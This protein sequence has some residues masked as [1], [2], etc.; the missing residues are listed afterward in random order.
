M[1]R[2]EFIRRTTLAAGVAVLPFSIKRSKK[3]LDKIEKPVIAGDWV[4]MFNPNDTRSEIATTWYTND[5]C[6]SKGPE[7]KWHAYGIIGHKPIDPW[8]GETK[9]FH[10]SADSFDQKRW[11]DHDYA[12]EVKPGVERV[13][14]AP[15]VYHDEGSEWWHMFYNIGNRQENAPDYASWGQL[16]RADSKDMFNW[17][18]H[19]LNP[20][21]SDPGHARDSFVTKIGDHYHFYYTRTLN[22]VDLRSAVALRTS[23]DLKYWSGAQIVHIQPEGGHWAGNTESPTVIERNSL[24]YLFI[25]RAMVKYNQTH[26]YWSEDPTHFPEEN[27]VCELPTHASEIIKVSEDEWYISNTG[28]DKEGLF[29]AKLEWK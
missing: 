7:G 26:V 27:L 2:K 16:C 3:Q 25:C 5:H 4:H 9:L 18:R 11:E 28:W 14:W 21:F 10:I 17:E 22:E 20:L 13:L 15:H 8:T 1:D 19:A 23:P 12:L 6:F 24:F 29:T